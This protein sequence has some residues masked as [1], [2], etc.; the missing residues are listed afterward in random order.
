MNKKHLTGIASVA[1][2]ALMGSTAAWGAT[3]ASASDNTLTLQSNASYNNVS[4][5][6]DDVTSFGTINTIIVD[7]GGVAAPTYSTIILP[8]AASEID[9]NIEAVFR[10]SAFHRNGDDCTLD[11]VSVETMNANEP[12]FIKLKDDVSGVTSFTFKAEG[13]VVATGESEHS[14]NLSGT[15]FSV[16]G[17]YSTKTWT[18]D[19]YNDYG[20]AAGDG[21]GAAYAGQ[22]VKV[23]SGVSLYPLRAY[24][25]CHPGNILAKVASSVEE[26]LPD[27]INV[28]FLDEKGNTLSIAKMNTKTGEFKTQN[29]YYDLKGRKLNSKPQNKIM[30]VN[31]K[32]IKH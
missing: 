5:S 28:R 31:K 30:Y 11:A 21:T 29:N 9:D 17:V 26:S 15:C 27:V 7:R 2:I 20:F 23:G 19:S 14:I 25:T 32:T 18:T 10:P 16:T 13:S 1:T 8:A 4:I 22:F 12:Y 24:L 3:G 6:P